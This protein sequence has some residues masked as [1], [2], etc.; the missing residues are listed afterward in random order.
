MTWRESS[1][2]GGRNRFARNDHVGSRFGETS[3]RD[4][5]GSGNSRPRDDWGQPSSKKG[6]YE[7]AG[8]NSSNGS[9]RTMPVPS[10]DLGKII[11]R[12]GSKI[13]QLEE[14]SGARVKVFFLPFQS[15]TI[16]YNCYIYQVIKDEN[17]GENSSVL[18]SGSDA[19]QQKA[20]ELISK[21]LDS[22]FQSNSF[23]SFGDSTFSSRGSHP[24]PS[25][26]AV[27]VDWGA[28]I[29]NSVS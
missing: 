11:G 23:S 29:Q 15:C 1:D 27:M 8:S 9:S 22:G 26:E 25:D 4:D 19:A 21:L 10:R 6:F 16:I 14:E 13:K 2:N 18:I 3:A 24:K 5:W 12:G 28:V 7:N 20:E 17:G